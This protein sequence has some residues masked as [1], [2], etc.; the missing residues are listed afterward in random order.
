MLPPAPVRPPGLQ[1]LLHLEDPEA[2]EGREG[3]EGLE[4]LPARTALYLLSP[5]DALAA[6]AD[7]RA[8]G[9]LLWKTNLATS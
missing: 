4:Y 7:R 3:L 5:H 6:Q 9:L 1:G 8:R 2:P